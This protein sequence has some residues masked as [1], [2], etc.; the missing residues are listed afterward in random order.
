LQMHKSRPSHAATVA[1]GIAAGANNE[2][3][4]HKVM[5]VTSEW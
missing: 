5:N 3:P 2:M 4:G 1:V